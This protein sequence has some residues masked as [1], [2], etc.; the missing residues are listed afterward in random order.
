MKQEIC[1]FQPNI[2]LH[3][4]ILTL[5]VFIFT[6]SNISAQGKLQT[7]ADQVS[8]YLPY[9]KSKKIAC[10]VNQTSRIGNTHL[11]DTLV[12]SGVKV[13]KIFAPEHGFRGSSEAG[14]KIGDSIDSKSGLPI[15]SLYGKKYKPS[16]T[17]LL[18]INTIVFDIQDVGVRFYTYISTLHYIMQ[19]C[20]D[21]NI[22][23]IVLDRPNPNRHY[24]DG[25]V[26]DT[27][28]KSFVGMHPVPI[29]Y[30][31][32][33][34]EYAL[35]I[36][37]EGWLSNNKKCKLK[38][39]K[40]MNYDFKRSCDLPVK[41][42]PNLPN[43][44]SVLLYPSLCL[45]EG[46]DVSVGRGTDLPF[47]QI[48]APWFTEKEYSFIPKAI[49]G[50]SNTPPFMNKLCY[51]VDLSKTEIKDLVNSPKLDLKYIIDFY[52]NSLLKDKFFN[53][54]FDK[55]AGNNQLRKDIINHIPENEIREK[56]NDKLTEYHLTREKYTIYDKVSSRNTP[57]EWK[58]K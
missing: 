21:N 22:E 35:M 42:S 47:Q 56:W 45:F 50:V 57:N 29:V 14:A 7:G 26:L 10:V 39:I 3:K 15:I 28:F 38:V 11:V 8:S 13:M 19:A 9:L 41:P 44:L 55:L 18:E 36:N 48:G 51:G 12:N 27:A 32:T 34:G 58:K 1:D 52:E 53:S 37:G 46:T 20:V 30:G 17:D 43:Q 6:F 4:I 31:L 33:I 49:L 54:F 5:I 24:V 16:A 23:L 2:I 25:P 40:L